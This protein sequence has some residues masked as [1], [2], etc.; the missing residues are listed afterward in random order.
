MR[1]AMFVNG[2]GRDAFPPVLVLRRNP[3]S[4]VVPSPM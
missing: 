1:H 4:V 2:A 3:E